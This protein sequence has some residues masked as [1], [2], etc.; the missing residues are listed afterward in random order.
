M[1]AQARKVTCPQCGKG[2]DWSTSNPFRP[3]CSERCKLIDLGQWA[4]ENYR[5]PV[6]EIQVPNGSADKNKN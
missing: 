1:A 6:E 3:F 2:V 5:I 4:T